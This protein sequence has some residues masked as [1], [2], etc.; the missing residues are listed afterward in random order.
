MNYCLKHGL[1]HKK[2]DLSLVTWHLKIVL[3]ALQLHDLNTNIYT[4]SLDEPNLDRPGSH[5]D[6]R[7]SLTRR[8][9]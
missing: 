1:N 3:L 8:Y 4:I 2:W 7:H 6:E 9:A 5:T